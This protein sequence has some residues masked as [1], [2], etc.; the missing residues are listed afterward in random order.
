MSSQGGV[1]R[2]QGLRQAC[3]LFPPHSASSPRTRG[4]Q[5]QQVILLRGEGETPSRKLS[6]FKQR[7]K[8]ISPG[9][10]RTGD[11]RGEREAWESGHVSNKVNK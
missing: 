11:F 5:R 7:P 3:R 9:E 6:A 8:A 4:K 10:E 1:P 2:G